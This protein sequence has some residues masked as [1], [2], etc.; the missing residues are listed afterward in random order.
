MAMVPHSPPGQLLGPGSSFQQWLKVGTI[1]DLLLNL[2][3]VLGASLEGS[4]PVNERKVPG[5]KDSESNQPGLNPG[6]ST[7]QLYEP[8]W[9]QF[10]HLQ[11]GR[12]SSSNLAELRRPNQILSD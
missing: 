4:R 1:L 2:R 6:S 3:S 10:P 9:P 12:D 7:D 8:P 5:N 11:S